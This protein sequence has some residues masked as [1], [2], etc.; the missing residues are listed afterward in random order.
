MTRCLDSDGKHI[1][2]LLL[3]L[4]IKHLPQL[5]EKGKIYIAVPPLFRRTSG[6]THEYFYSN[7][8][9]EKN[10]IKGDVTRFKGIE[11]QSLSIFPTYW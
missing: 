3:T 2:L 7:E 10:N 9:L 4:F 5:I 11:C 6:R 1:N 8:E